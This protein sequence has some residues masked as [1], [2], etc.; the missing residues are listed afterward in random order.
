MLAPARPDRAIVL[1]PARHPRLRRRCSHV[2]LVGKRGLRG[3]FPHRAHGESSII[4]GL[5]LL[6]L[7]RPS[8]EPADLGALALAGLIAAPSK[9]L[10][11]IRRGHIFNPAAIGAV[12]VALLGFGFAGWWVATPGLLPAT[13]IT[14]V[15]VLYRSGRL[16]LGAFFVCLTAALVTAY[17]TVTGGIP[18]P[19]AIGTALLSYPIVFLAGFM[20]SE[21]LTLPP[22]RWQQFLTATVVAVLFALPQSIGGVFLGPEFA[23]VIGNLLAFALSPR[24]RIHLEYLGRTALTP[25]SWEFVFRPRRSPRFLPGQFMELTLPH[26]GAD[27]RGTRRMF[28]IVDGAH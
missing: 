7:F 5:L 6:F 25:T 19:N 13:T 22:R 23:L 18:L 3:Y 10:L 8:L 28:S 21:P 12:I 24:R 2:Q 4:T 20:L 16:A 27:L 17:L 26:R 11:A 9:Y 15:L 14:A 1:Q